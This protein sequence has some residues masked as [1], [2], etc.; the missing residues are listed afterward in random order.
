MLC[1]RPAD[2]MPLRAEPLGAANINP[3]VDAPRFRPVGLPSEPLGLNPAKEN[4][5]CN[6]V[7]ME[8]EAARR[9]AERPH[10]AQPTNFMTKHR[11]WLADMA[12]KKVRA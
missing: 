3:Q 2:T 9:R 12:G 4:V 6:V 10:Q 1:N 7:A 5:V 8:R 11:K